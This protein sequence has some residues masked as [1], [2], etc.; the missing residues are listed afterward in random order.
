M[1]TQ[2]SVEYSKGHIFLCCGLIVN[3]PQT[4]NGWSL[5]TYC[6]CSADCLEEC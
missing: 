5:F 2:P 3:I 4:V 6:G 1:T